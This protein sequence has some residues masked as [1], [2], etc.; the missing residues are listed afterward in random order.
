MEGEINLRDRGLIGHGSGDILI[1]P[2]IHLGQ[3]RNLSGK[4][5]RRNLDTSEIDQDEASRAGAREGTEKGRGVG[6]GGG[7]VKRGGISNTRQKERV[8]ARLAP[9]TGY[10]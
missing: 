4:T 2:V 7:G 3:W 10:F 5:D 8:E 6:V 9:G 1:H